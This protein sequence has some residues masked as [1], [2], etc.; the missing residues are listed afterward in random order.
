M[1]DWFKVT[2]TVTDMEEDGSV[3]W[4]V[5]PDGPAVDT[6][7]AQNL[8]QFQAGAQLTASVTDLDNATTGNANGPVTG[9]TWKWYRSSSKTGPWSEIFGETEA[10]YTAS[11]EAESNDVGM[12]L[13]A[14]ATYSDRRGGNKLADFV[15]HYPVQEAKEI[16]TDPEF[17]STDATRSVSE[18]PSG[19]DVG[20]PVTASDADNDVLN[21]SLVDPGTGDATSSQST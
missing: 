6:E 19:R 12:Y 8:R 14:V 17:P 9:A 16:N 7:S 5:D 21:Y 11:D 1:G 4:M 15:S 10:T 2:V 3:S 20:A 18:G 13:R